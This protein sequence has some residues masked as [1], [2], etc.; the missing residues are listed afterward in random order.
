MH[1]SI[2]ASIHALSVFPSCLG[3]K[4]V[5]TQGNILKWKPLEQEVPSMTWVCDFLT[6][7]SMEAL[8]WE[9]RAVVFW[10]YCQYGQI[11]NVFFL[12]FND[13]LRWSNWTEWVGWSD[14]TLSN[15]VQALLNMW[16]FAWASLQLIKPLGP[17][18]CNQCDGDGT[19]HHGDEE[20]QCCLHGQS[21]GA[22]W[23]EELK[24]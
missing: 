7:G 5:V 9:H 20:L 3:A 6:T 21:L 19:D 23:T 16:H 1:P 15:F 2:H 11:Q 13:W 12:L 18:R 4:V 10:H 22:E 14:L 24:E 8:F 17:F